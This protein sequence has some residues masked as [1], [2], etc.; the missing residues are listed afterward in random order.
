VERLRDAT[1]T[2][3]A[4]IDKKDVAAL[5]DSSLRLDT[6]C[7]ACH[8]IYWYPKDNISK[9]LFEQDEKQYK[10]KDKQ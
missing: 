7:E 8:V 10:T 1:T 5:E 6:A 3:L 9:R 2:V 4:A